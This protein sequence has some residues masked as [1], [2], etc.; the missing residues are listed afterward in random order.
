MTKIEYNSE[1]KKE[2]INNLSNA[3]NSLGTI[4]NSFYNTFIP[5]DFYYYNT[6]NKMKSSIIESRKKL[7]NY[8]DKINNRMESINKDE[9]DIA[10]NV[11]KIEDFIIEKF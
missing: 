8:K 6:T 7:L 1:K 5:S 3:I 2:T 9:L 4:N 10:L 11:T